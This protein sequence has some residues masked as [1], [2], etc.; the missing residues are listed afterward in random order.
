MV[1]PARL[2]HLVLKV[3][4]IKRSEE[5]YKEILGL[6]VTE[7][8]FGMVFL[9]SS[10]E[11]S[12]EL[13]LAPKSSGDDD[14]GPNS[15]LSHFAWQMKTTRDLRELQEF[16]NENGIRILGTSDHGISIG[17]YFADPDG[18][19]VEV[20]YELPRESWPRD[21]LFKGRFPKEGFWGA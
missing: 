14:R 5:F 2:G 20:F 10:S 17:V 6:K 12:H 13:A 21:G 7:R 4:D 9:S 15:R 11:T 1:S 3:N 8:D 19:H 18:N 16:L